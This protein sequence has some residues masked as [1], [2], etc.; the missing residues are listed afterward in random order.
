M[1]SSSFSFVDVKEQSLT[2][3]RVGRKKR[4]GGK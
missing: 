4:I 3:R 2:Y 1:P